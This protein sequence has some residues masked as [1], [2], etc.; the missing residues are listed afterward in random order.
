MIWLAT[1]IA[2]VGAIGGMNLMTEVEIEQAE[3]VYP[4]S[5]K[6]VDILGAP[7]HY[8]EMGEGNTPT[9]VLLHG[10]GG[11]SYAWYKRGIIDSLATTCHV[12]AFDRA[13]HGHS[14]RPNGMNGDPR[15]QA[16]IIHRAILEL[17]IEKPV[18]VGL[19]WGGAVAASY[20]VEYPDDLAAL[21]LLAP[22]ILPNERT[23]DIVY[24]VAQIPVL[25][26]ALLHTLAVP[27]GC[28]VRNPLTKR[29]FS[30][31]P[32]PDDYWG[33]TILLSQRP[34]AVKIMADDMSAVNTALG[35]ESEKYGAIQVP[36]GIMIGEHDVY[37]S[38]DPLPAWADSLGWQYRQI[39]DAGHAIHYTRAAEVV[40][41][42]REMVAFSGSDSGVDSYKSAESLGGSVRF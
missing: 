4:D 7:Q 13:G 24:P 33:E 42:I 2:L 41:F 11:S 20:A 25:S 38:D 21:A 17:G 16:D 19:S 8:F 6:Y 23:V 34:Q 22:Y 32:V 35:E 36:V 31:E 18:I 15:A 37:F 40:G 14:K 26:D 3:Q 5:G 9:I 1:L 30:P 39:P 10:V 29:T 27:V 28:L 12:Y